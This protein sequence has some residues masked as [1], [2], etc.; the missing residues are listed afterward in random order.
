MGVPYDS[1]HGTD[2]VG[3][4]AAKPSNFIGIA[5][6]ARGWAP[7]TGFVSTAAIGNESRSDNRSSE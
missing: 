2:C 6:A 1:D 3:V 7:A 5:G 4:I